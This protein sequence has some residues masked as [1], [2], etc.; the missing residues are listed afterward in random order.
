MPWWEETVDCLL[1]SGK[2]QFEMKL[3]NLGFLSI[4]GDA[5]SDEITQT[6]GAV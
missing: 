2:Y 3:V 1:V 5:R 4:S 6:H